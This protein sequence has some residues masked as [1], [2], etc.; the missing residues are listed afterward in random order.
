[1]K[2]SVYNRQKDLKVSAVAVKK[3]VKQALEFH[4]INCDEIAIHL[5]TDRAMRKLHEDFF[6]DP[7]PTDCISFPYDKDGSSG[8]FF[9]GEV[10]ICPKTA[11]QYIAKKGSGDLYSEITLYLIHGILHLLGYD[12]INSNDLKVMRSK[13]RELMSFLTQ[14]TLVLS[15]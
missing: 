6:N 11:F 2:I 4:Q 5:I 15:S 13:E 12:D 1:M 14:K 8:Y 3:T 7:T 10:F 9:L